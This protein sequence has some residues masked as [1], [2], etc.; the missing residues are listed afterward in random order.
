MFLNKIIIKRPKE[1][2]KPANANKKKEVD[3]KFISSFNEPK[4]TDST[5]K[6]TQTISEY[7]NKLNKLFEFKK[8]RNNDSQ[9]IVFQNINQLCIKLYL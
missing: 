7:N 1:N 3:N 4:Q 2:S 6:I 5:Y 8:N 9:N